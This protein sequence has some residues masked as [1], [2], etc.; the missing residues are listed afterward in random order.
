MIMQNLFVNG[1]SFNGPRN[2]WGSE[3]NTW[4]GKEIANHYGVTLHHFA[5]GGRGNRRICDTTKIF[6][7]QNLERKK[8]TFAVIQWSSPGRRDYPTN[9]GY[10]Q[11]QGY[12]T[13]WRTWSTHEQLKF[14]GQQKGWDVEQDHS[15]LQLTQILDL[16]HYFIINK[17]RYVMYFGLIP[18]IDLKYKDHQTLF[19]ALDK[20][21]FFNF[22]TSH[23]EFCKSN[24][25]QLSEHD[26]HPSIDGHKQWAAQLI[27]HMD[28]LI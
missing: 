5:R 11:I 28:Q 24:N 21:T 12:S 1:C 3:C 7:E 6:F 23:Y 2:K 16:Q 4:V 13:S 27:K 20:K 19:N 14:I 17:I 15:L 9:D 26:E 8:D 22:E 10:K 18:Q 25:L